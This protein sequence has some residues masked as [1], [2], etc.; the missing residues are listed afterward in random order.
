MRMHQRKQCDEFAAGT[1]GNVGTIGV[2][3]NAGNTRG[4]ARALIRPECIERSSR[5]Q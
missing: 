3:M 2:R 1:A 4:T 5:R